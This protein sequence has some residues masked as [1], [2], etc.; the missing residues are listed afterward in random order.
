MQNQKSQRLHS[1]DALRGFTMSWIIGGGELV[2][3]LADAT[4][5]QV[6]QLFSNQLR[7][8]AWNGLF[9]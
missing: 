7:H 6:L 4:D 2:H 3:A 8:V 5:W 1:L 9:F